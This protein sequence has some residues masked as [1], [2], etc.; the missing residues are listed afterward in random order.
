LQKDRVTAEGAGRTDCDDTKE[1][2][3]ARIEVESS[4]VGERRTSGEWEVQPQR[5]W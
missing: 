1:D 4:V 5:V 3:S 2:T